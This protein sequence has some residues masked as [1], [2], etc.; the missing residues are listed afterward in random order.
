VALAA[1]LAFFI[2]RYAH[3][4]GDLDERNRDVIIG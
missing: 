1:L 2:S 3:V 4:G